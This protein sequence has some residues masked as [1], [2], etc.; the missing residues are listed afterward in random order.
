[1]HHMNMV[2]CLILTLTVFLL[3]A[4][5]APHVQTASNVT[6]LPVLTPDHVVMDDGYVLPLSL[7]RPEQEPRAVVLALHGFNDYRNAFAGVGPRLAT[8]GIV[9]YAYDQRGFGETAQRGIWPGSDRLASDLDALSRLLCAEYPDLPQYLLGESMGAAV[10][11]E[12]L[13]QM[14]ARCVSGVVLMAPAVW[15]WRTMPLWQQSALW[16]AA[17]IAPGSKVSGEGLDIIASDNIEML[18][19]LG[20]DPLVIKQSR[21]D[22]IFGLTS[23][24]DAALIA[25]SGLTIPGLIL[26]GEKDEIIPALP[27]CRMLNALPGPPAGQWR[28]VLY[29]QGYHMLSRDLHS[30]TVLDDVLAWLLDHNKQLPSGFEITKGDIRLQ[31]MCEATPVSGDRPAGTHALRTF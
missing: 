25:S 15:G 22:T 20:R 27:V 1:M 14:D 4:C 3:V 17:H 24:M 10:I 7:W 11:L 6:R 26:Y 12:A 18:R 28:F 21:I 13:Q 9:T 23:L 2:R 8:G 19:A 29:P 5:A 30:D 16:L 31:T